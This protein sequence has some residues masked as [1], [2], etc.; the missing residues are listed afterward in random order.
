MADHA[1]AGGHASPRND[2]PLTL[3]IGVLFSLF[4]GLLVYFAARILLAVYLPPENYNFMDIVQLISAATLGLIVAALIFFP[5]MFEIK[6]GE[7]AYEMLLGVPLEWLSVG[8][9]YGWLL[10]LFMSIKIRPGRGLTV[11]PGEKMNTTENGIEVTSN[12][13]GT[14]VIADLLTL[15]KN[16]EGS[17]VP[18]FVEAVL[19]AAVRD[20]IADE[21]VRV[22]Q[23]FQ[24]GELTT[25]MAFQIIAEIAKFKHTIEKNGNAI[26]AAVNEQLGLKGLEL[27]TL[28]I[29]DVGL[30]KEIEDAAKR[31]VSETIEAGGLTKDAKNKATV[32]GELMKVFEANG[33]K[34]ADLPQEVAADLIDRSLDRAMAAED[35]ASIKRINFGGTPPRGTFT[36][37][38]DV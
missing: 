31:V 2:T 12:V 15:D 1:H 34:L 28:Q 13:A 5:G 27:S 16:I 30:P 36:N 4:V 25:E 9:G 22:E 6:P 23:A 18:Q 29:E 8:P 10:P 35:K 26:K 24:Q 38:G 3:W 21:P 14:Y 37:V 17:A 33:V 11:N 32:A 20:A 19:V 7:K